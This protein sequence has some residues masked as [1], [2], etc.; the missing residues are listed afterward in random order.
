MNCVNVA[1]VVL[2]GLSNH[3]GNLK[4]SGPVNPPMIVTVSQERPFEWV[5]RAR[6][7]SLSPKSTLDDLKRGLAGEGIVWTN[8]PSKFI[9]ETRLL[10][11]DINVLSGVLYDEILAAFPKQDGEIKKFRRSDNERLFNLASDFHETHSPDWKRSGAPN[12][13]GEVALVPMVADVLEINGKRQQ[14]YANQYPKDKDDKPKPFAISK[15][16]DELA[17]ENALRLQQPESRVQ[18]TVS[19]RFSGTAEPSLLISVG[20]VLEDIRSRVKEGLNERMKAKGTAEQYP[21]DAKR[22]SDYPEW[23]REILRENIAQRYKEFGFSSRE[24]AL[25]GADKLMFRENQV[26][27]SVEF[28][29][30]DPSGT[31]VKSSG[32]VIRP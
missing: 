15:T 32:D 29:R 19:R 26:G 23:K 7:V 31:V 17:K 3:Q 13:D 18:V 8:G 12:S 14:I 5:E 10:Q 6:L 1:L 28:S 30:V 4:P 27:F 24:Q 9:I 20:K 22:I 25:Q 21:K 11:G 2:V 16:Y